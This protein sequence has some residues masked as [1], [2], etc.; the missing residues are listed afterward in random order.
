MEI[1]RVKHVLNCVV[2][3]LGWPSP[4]I[5]CNLVLDSFVGGELLWP[6]KSEVEVASHN[7]LSMGQTL[8]SRNLLTQPI[9]VG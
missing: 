7:G 8:N 4:T 9:G 2:P 3:H 1:I 6:S 5:V